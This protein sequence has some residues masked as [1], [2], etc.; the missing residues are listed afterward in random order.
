MP[1]PATLHVLSARNGNLEMP[2]YFLK[3]EQGYT[4][5]ETEKGKLM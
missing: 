1:F 2:V 3:M 4:V 5:R